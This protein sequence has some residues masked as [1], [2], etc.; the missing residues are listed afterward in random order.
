MIMSNTF[1]CALSRAQY[2]H[3]L[4]NEPLGIFDLLQDEPHIHG[5]IVRLSLAAAIHSVLADER[6]G[7]CQDIQCCREPSPNRTHLKLI[8]FAGFAVVIEHDLRLKIVVKAL[9]KVHEGFESEA[10]ATRLVIL[11]GFLNQK[12]PCNV[13]VRPRGTLGNEFLEE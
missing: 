4:N 13:Q 8:T 2:F 5:R 12:R 6:E 7:I 3:C 10:D 11:P 9:G 1:F